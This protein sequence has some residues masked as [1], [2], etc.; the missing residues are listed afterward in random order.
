MRI[1]VTQKHINV[2]VTE[3]CTHCPIGLVLIEKGMEE[4]EVTESWVRFQYR[5]EVSGELIREHCPLP[6]D[7]QTFVRKF[8][9]EEQV[10]PFEFTL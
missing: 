5:D 2:G 4:I 1:K 6:K 3:S 8:D 9:N 10:E 7:A